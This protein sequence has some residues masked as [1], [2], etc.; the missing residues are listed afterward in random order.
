MAKSLNVHSISGHLARDPKVF[1]NDGGDRSC[2]M[3][4]AVNGSKK[5]DGEWQDDPIFYDVRV[6]GA[7]VDAIE[8]WLHK[9]SFCV[10][11]GRGSH[12]RM[13]T[14]EGGETR[15]TPTIVARSVVFGPKTNGDGGEPQ[16]SAPAAKPKPKADVAAAFGDDD[17]IPF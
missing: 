3:T 12:P 1:D 2:V 16:R 10:V 7:Q 11:E 15:A 13:Y 8:A 5:V 14:P 6:Y 9:G 4:V 17:D